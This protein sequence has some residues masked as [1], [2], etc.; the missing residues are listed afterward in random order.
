M[1]EITSAMSYLNSTPV[2]LN[3]PLVDSE[4]FPRDDLDLYA[5]SG[6]RHTVACVQND[7]RAIEE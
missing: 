2:G 7:L 3:E 6:A 5:I 4:G 1:N